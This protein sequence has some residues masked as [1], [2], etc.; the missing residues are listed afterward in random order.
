MRA[1]LEPAAEP[2]VE[3]FAGHERYLPFQAPSNA[4]IRL[5][6]IVQIVPVLLN[7]GNQPG[8]AVRLGRNS[9]NDWRYSFAVVSE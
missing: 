2:K 5:T 1:F 9:L 3:V 8:N 6:T 4:F 7:F